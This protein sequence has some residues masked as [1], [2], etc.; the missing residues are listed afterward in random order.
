MAKSKEQKQ[1]EALERK[2]AMFDEKAVWYRQH[3][4]GGDFYNDFCNRHNREYAEKRKNEVSIVFARYLVEAQLDY[5]GNPVDGVAEVSS[6]LR[7]GQ[8]T[9]GCAK[10]KQP[11][12]ETSPKH[13]NGA[14]HS[15]LEELENER[16]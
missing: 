8:A 15:Y 14:I 2:R 1:Q 3:Q 10:G 16:W 4:V 11:K 5:H 12:W 9:I 7:I 6:K 13:D